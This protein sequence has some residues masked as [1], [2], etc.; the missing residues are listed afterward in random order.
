[1]AGVFHGGISPKLEDAEVTIHTLSPG[2]LSGLPPHNQARI[3]AGIEAITGTYNREIMV[4]G[5]TNGRAVVCILQSA[6]DDTLYKALHQTVKDA[7]TRQLSGTRLGLLLV[8]LNG[9]PREALVELARDD[10][11]PGEPPSLLR[12]WASQFF[13]DTERRDRCYRS[14]LPEPQRRWP[15]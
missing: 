5:F 7:A 1:M 8:E 10:H 12:A 2:L 15:V 11:I 13:A 6:K 9:L 3:R 4:K 14:C